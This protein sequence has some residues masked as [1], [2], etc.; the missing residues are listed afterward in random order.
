VHQVSVK[1]EIRARVS[2]K[3]GRVSLKIIEEK[4]IEK[5]TGSRRRVSRMAVTSNRQ[6]L[7]GR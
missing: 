6:S 1:K 4:K 5:T 3:K 7:L 2:L